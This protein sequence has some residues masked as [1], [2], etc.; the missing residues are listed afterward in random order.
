MD[1]QTGHDEG[2]MIPIGRGEILLYQ[3]EDGRTR[4]ECRFQDETIWLSQALMARLYQIS[5]PSSGG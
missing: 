3:R 1:S 2:A 5:R 4:I